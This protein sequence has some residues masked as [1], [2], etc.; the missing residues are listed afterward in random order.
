MSVTVA[1]YGDAPAR[2]VTVQLEQ[3]GDA[4]PALVLDDIPPRDEVSH[5]FRVQFA[6]IGGHSL[7]A[8]LPRRRGRR[9]QPPLLRL[10]SA[11]RPAGADRRWL[12]RRPRRP[13]TF[14]RARARRQHA[15]RLAA[16]RRAAQVSGRYR[17][18]STSKR[19]F[20]CSMCRDLA[21]DEAGRSGNYVRSGGGVAFFVGADTDRSFYNDRLYQTAR[22]CSPRRSSCP[23]SSWIAR[24]N[25]ARRGSHPASAVSSPRRPAQR[26]P[27]ADDGRLLLRARG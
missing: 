13:P 19:P 1:N 15:H 18:A 23:R 17:N 22:A 4:L 25:H 8:S 21:D 5:K 6:G 7:T 14:A 20:V 11:G 12:A 10:R 26:F 9:R 3:D 24:R 2:G 27:A 16:A